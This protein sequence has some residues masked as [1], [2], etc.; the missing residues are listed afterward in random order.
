MDRFL[1]K[2]MIDPIDL[3]FFEDLADIPIQSLCGLQI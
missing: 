3:V 2:V 1:A